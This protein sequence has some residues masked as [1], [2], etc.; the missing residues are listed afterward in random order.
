MRCIE[1]LRMKHTYIYIL[2]KLICI[3]IHIEWPYAHRPWIIGFCLFLLLFCSS[4]SDVTNE[5]TSVIFEDTNRKRIEEE[6]MKTT[7]WNLY[8]RITLPQDL[9]QIYCFLC[10]YSVCSS[11]VS[12]GSQAFFFFFSLAIAN[13]KTT[14]LICGTLL[15]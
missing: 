2:S 6:E 11:S 13:R 5:D 4:G 14:M 15:R 8:D 1:K 12:R 3:C 10:F 9:Y 7:S